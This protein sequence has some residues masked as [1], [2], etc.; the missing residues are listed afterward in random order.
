MNQPYKFITIGKVPGDIYTYTRLVY[1]EETIILDNEYNEI[2]YSGW[3]DARLTGA[4]FHEIA[5][6]YVKEKSS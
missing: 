4:F 5:E 2:D 1:S 3:L 6:K